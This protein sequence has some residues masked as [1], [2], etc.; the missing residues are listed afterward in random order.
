MA[1]RQAQKDFLDAL[2]YREA[3]LETLLLVGT[4]FDLPATQNL[5]ADRLNELELKEN[6]LVTNQEILRM[7]IDLMKESNAKTTRLRF[8]IS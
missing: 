5:L 6:R 2:K 8:G 7:A 3:S 1:L 4:V